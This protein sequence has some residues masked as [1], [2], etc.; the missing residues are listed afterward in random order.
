[1]PNW[2]CT[3]FFGRLACKRL[4]G[5]VAF[6]HGFVGESAHLRS[7]PYHHLIH[8]CRKLVGFRLEQ[9]RVS[10][11]LG[12]LWPFRT[13]YRNSGVQI[14][15]AWAKAVGEKFPNTWTWPSLCLRRI[16]W[17]PNPVGSHPKHRVYDG[18]AAA[19]YQRD[20][21]CGT[22]PPSPHSQYPAQTLRFGTQES[23]SLSRGCGWLLFSTP[24][25][26]ARHHNHQKKLPSRAHWIGIYIIENWRRAPAGNDTIGYYRQ[27]RCYFFMS[28]NKWNCYKLC[29]CVDTYLRRCIVQP[30]HQR[31]LLRHK[32]VPHC[33]T[34]HWWPQGLLLNSKESG[35]AIVHQNTSSDM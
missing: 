20:P 23:G 34:F 9:D 7:G 33:R 26:P 6:F 27:I 2:A 18:W 32:I 31:H 24:S 25:A 1:M 8:H 12:V 5:D 10:S 14:Q 17:A 11:Q 4:W 19:A 15:F 3:W 21:C 22:K 30:L 16:R 28:N 29:L 35:N 13:D